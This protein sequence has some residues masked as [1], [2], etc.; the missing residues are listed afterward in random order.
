MLNNPS[1]GSQ[2]ILKIS[3]SLFKP[4][5]RERK[6]KPT[7]NWEGRKGGKKGEK[8]GGKGSSQKIDPAH[9][10]SPHKRQ[11][12]SWEPPSYAR[13]HEPNESSI[14]KNQPKKR[15]YI[16]IMER[17]SSAV[18]QEGEMAVAAASGLGATVTAA[19]SSLPFFCDRAKEIRIFL[20]GYSWCRF[21]KKFS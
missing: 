9:P 18:E 3:Q 5:S 13:A 15:R 19:A 10:V 20:V 7:R 12:E 4:R 21:R 6:G 1:T 16:Y 2:Y 8:G 14:Q 11:K 17:D